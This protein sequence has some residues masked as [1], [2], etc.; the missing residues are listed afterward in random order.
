MLFNS[1]HCK[2]IAPDIE[3]AQFRLRTIYRWY[4]YLPRTAYAAVFPER[5]WPRALARSPAGPRSEVAKWRTA[6]HRSN[7]MDT[8]LPIRLALCVEPCCVR[9]LFCSARAGF[10]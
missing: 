4:V 2:R 5:G 8:G 3:K 7:A 1:Y 9:S 10:S 6:M